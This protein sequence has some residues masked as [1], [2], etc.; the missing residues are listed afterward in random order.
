M[1]LFGRKLSTYIS[2]KWFMLLLLRY[3]LLISRLAGI[4]A[5]YVIVTKN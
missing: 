1:D 5:R 3:T 4:T 2:N